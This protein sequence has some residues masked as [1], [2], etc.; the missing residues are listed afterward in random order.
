M[1]I[2]WLVF[3]Y[4]YCHWYPLIINIVVGDLLGFNPLFSEWFFHQAIRLQWLQVQGS[5]PEPELQ[6]EQLAAASRGDQSRMWFYRWLLKMAIYSG[7]SH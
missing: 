2:V 3:G 5:A 7:F 6:A 1:V 4:H